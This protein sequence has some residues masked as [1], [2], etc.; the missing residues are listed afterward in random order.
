MQSSLAVLE[1]VA[2]PMKNARFLFRNLLFGF[3]TLMTVF[4][5]R[6]IP[7]PD[8]EVMGRLFV[9]GIQCCML[10]T[11]RD[12]REEKDMIDLFTSIIIDLPPETFHEVF[13][14][15][16]PFLFEQILRA[17][18]LLGIPQNLLSNDAVSRR[19]VEILLKFLVARLEDLG[20]PDKKLA[21]VSLRLFKMAFMAVTIFPE[22]NEAVLEPH[23]THL[24]LSLIHI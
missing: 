23:L 7:E 4:K 11:Q 3:K 10:Q 16:L 2:D 20:T 22:E 12:G 5:H 13:T 8:G 19:F 17:P 18:A 15:H 24:I 6:G 1:H 21:S 9:G 14:A